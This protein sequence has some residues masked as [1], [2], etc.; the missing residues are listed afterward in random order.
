MS[1]FVYLD[2]CDLDD[3]FGSCKKASSKFRT[4]AAPAAAASDALIPDIIIIRSTIICR[5][6]FD[7]TANDIFLLYLPFCCNQYLYCCICLIIAYET[8]IY[9]NT[10]KSDNV[11]F[12]LSIVLYICICL[13]FVFV[14]CI[15]KKASSKFRT[16]AASAAAASDAL[17]PDIIIIR[18]TIICRLIFDDFYYQSYIIFVFV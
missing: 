17:I 2:D 6:I 12:L 8:S 15:G 4:T 14:F 16:T 13:C 1:V 11:C 5:L 18:S 3:G 10:N 9:V 7:E